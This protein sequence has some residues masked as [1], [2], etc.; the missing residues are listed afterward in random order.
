M[1]EG[2]ATGA[3]F[4]DGKTVTYVVATAAGAGY[5]G[6]G[7]LTARYMEKHLPGSTFVVVNRPGAGH[8]IG[9]NLIYNAK[10]DGL[11]LGTFNM[12]VIYSQITGAKAA[13]YDL[14]KMSWIGKAASDTRTIMV[15]AASPYKTFDDLRAAAAPVPLAVSGV[16][17]AAY[18]EL[19]LLANVFD[20][21][22]KLLPGYSGAHVDLAM[23]RGEVAGKMGTIVG[24]IGLVRA[25]RGRFVLQ[26]GGSRDEIGGDTTYAADI[27]RTPDQKAVI[28]LI[29]AQGEMSRITAGPP[30]IPAD[31]LAAL[32]EAYGKAFGD[33]ELRA[34][35]AKLHYSIDP[36]VGEDVAKAIR[37]ALSQPPRIVA[38]LKDLQKAKPAGVTVTAPL[39][40]VEQ[41]GRVLGFTDASGQEVA[42]KISGSRSKIEIGGKDAQRSALKPG[43]A[44]AI[45]YAGPGGEASL[46]ACK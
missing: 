11:T 17:S 43:M 38:M 21:K 7:R 12:G 36:L 41:D 39:T 45:T 13:Q 6:Y 9:T 32:R 20:L 4:Y 30:E 3:E 35:A 14:G 24:Q 34:D 23:M 2:T 46:V 33:P 15:A 31:R 28:E 5:D 19:R 22:L 18:T 8:L 1:T 27:A 26:I 37:A 44:C 25:G 10:P 42:A 40:K 29:A 16:G